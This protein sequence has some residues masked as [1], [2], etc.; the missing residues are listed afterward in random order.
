[1]KKTEVKLLFLTKYRDFSYTRED[2][3]A[4]PS[5]KIFSSGLHNSVTFVV[6]MLKTRGYD[7]AHESCADNNEIDKY[8]TLHRPTHV[9]LEAL[10]VVPSKLD[11]LMPLHPT[12]QW[13]LR[14]HSEVP[15]IANE[16]IAIEWIHEYA[17]KGAFITANSPRMLDATEVILDGFVGYT[18]NFYPV[19]DG[20][21][22]HNDSNNLDIGCF[23]A[24]RPLKNHL[25]QAKAAMLYANQEGK[26][27]R[28]HI[29][30]TR[31]EGGGNPIL[32]NIRAL[33]DNSD[34]ELIEHD[35]LDHDAFRKLLSEIDCLLQVSFTE[36]FNIVAADAVTENVPVVTSSEV[37]FIASP[38]LAD[39]TDLRDI[40]KKIGRAISWGKYGI[41]GVNKWLLR[42]NADDAVK[43]W[44]R[45][46]ASL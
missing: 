11:V 9:I 16:G 12:V 46:I 4:N 21:W 6:D 41:H 23:G 33:F 22:E 8:V 44:D 35:W 38:F 19:V 10:W 25:M 29:N 1:M 36:T 17:N 31:V 15:F 14:L 7:V 45:W 20:R 40:A 24:I 27:L 39:P 32:K 3:C 43:A 30:G 26:H 42:R 5:S 13:G 28:F 34:H 37:M 18:P 2:S